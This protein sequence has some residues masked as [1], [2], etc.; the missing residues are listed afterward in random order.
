MSLNLIYPG[1]DTPNLVESMSDDWIISGPIRAAVHLSGVW[2]NL[3]PKAFKFETATSCSLRGRQTF[4]P[5]ILDHPWV[6]WAME[7]DGNYGW[8]YFYACDMAVEYERRFGFKPY[9]VTMLEV[10]EEMPDN[11]PEGEFTE[12][13]F[14][15]EIDFA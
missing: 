7:S 8:L 15:K 12:P 5:V 1:K 9:I 4:A 6:T 2:H 3:R 14:A 10:Y 13:L 11:V